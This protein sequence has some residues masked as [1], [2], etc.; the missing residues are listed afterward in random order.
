MNGW[1]LIGG[2]CY[3]NGTPKPGNPCQKCISSTNSQGWTASAEDTECDGDN[4][5]C[6]VEECQGGACV[7]TLSIVCIDALECED[8]T[9][10][11]TGATTHDCPNPLKDGW[12]LINGNCY[13]DGEDST[14]NG[15]MECRPELDTAGWS[16]K[17][18]CETCGS[19]ETPGGC[20]TEGYCIWGSCWQTHG[21]EE[22]CDACNFPDPCTGGIGVCVVEQIDCVVDGQEVTCGSTHPDNPN[23][24]CGWLGGFFPS[25]N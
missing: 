21:D 19:S 13:N 17:D 3:A 8:D 6:T 23:L 9:C 10:V 5:G 14:P 7:Q 12:C 20:P 18:D 16:P 22:I 15:C 2:V 4:N 1:C 11:N 25:C 24:M